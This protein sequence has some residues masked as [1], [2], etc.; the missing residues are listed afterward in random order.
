[1]YFNRV[2][3]SKYNN[4]KVEYNG[5]IFDSKKELRFFLYLKDLEKDNIIKDIK[6]QVKY[7]IQPAF[8]Y[9]GQA[10]RSINYIADFT[11]VVLD[12]EKFK[13]AI[14]YRDEKK[15]HAAADD[16]IKA[17]KTVILDTKGYK[18]EVYKLKYKLMLYRGHKIFEI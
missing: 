13:N 12:V 2:N 9:Q 7:E 17:G 18:T 14:G 4:N 15:G 10:I 6:R 16:D 1:M 5:V 3:Y 11:V 8:R